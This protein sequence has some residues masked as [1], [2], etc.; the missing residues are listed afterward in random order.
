MKG[1]ICVDF[2]SSL[3]NLVA[4]NMYTYSISNAI[5]IVPSR[6]TESIL[7]KM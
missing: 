1:N 5:A 7:N 4:F 2:V 3:D 6:V